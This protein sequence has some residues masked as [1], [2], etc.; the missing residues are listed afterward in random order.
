MNDE[1]SRP[2][3]SATRPTRFA[4]NSN[5]NTTT[6][7]S[8][9]T[10]SA[11]MPT[12]GLDHT[13]TIYPA[14][15]WWSG[16]LGLS[17]ADAMLDR[18]ASA[19]FSTDWGTRDISNTTLLLRSDQLPPGLRLAAVHGLGVAGRVSCGSR[20]V[21]LRA[22]DAER[23]THLDAGPGR[24]HRTA[25]GRVFSAAGPQQ[26]AP[27]LVFRDGDYARAA[28]A[29][30]VGLGRAW[31]RTL[32]LAPHLPA[33]WDTAH[34]HNVPLGE[35][36]IDLDLRAPG[37]Q[38]LVHAH[39]ASAEVILPSLAGRAARSRTVR[40]AANM[41]ELSMPLPAVE[42]G[43]P[44][45]SA[46]APAHGRAQ[47]KAVGERRDANRYELKLEASGGSALQLPVRL[48]RPGVRAGGAELAGSI[49][50]ISVSGAATAISDATVSVHMV[51]PIETSPKPRDAL[52]RPSGGRSGSSQR[53][54]TSSGSRFWPTSS[55]HGSR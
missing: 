30:R 43:I 29:V 24:G 16:R 54:P 27:D 42:V 7:T 23:R 15:A 32:R 10:L 14:V 37:G 2:R 53:A 13:A 41:H 25:L 40:P 47:L 44:H 11:G 6:L 33:T 20:A 38:L 5:P 50:R 55:R 4:A 39:S 31:H 48:N 8:G 52:I 21:G 34:L 3:G 19:E 1:R 49:C 9:S 28:R 12:A 26:F 17:K 36:R 35:S 22:P 18:W 45:E 51:R 46:V